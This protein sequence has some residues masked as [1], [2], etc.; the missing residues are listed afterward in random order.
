MD[1]KTFAGQPVGSIGLSNGT[2]TVAASEAH[3][4]PSLC[5]PL[6]NKPS[7]EKR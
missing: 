7:M 2:L 6:T 5:T 4:T 1:L 3:P